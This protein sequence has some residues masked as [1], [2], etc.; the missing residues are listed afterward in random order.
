MS[1]IA[2]VL[3]FERTE[4]DDAQVSEVKVDPGGGANVTAQHFA[5]PG[6][7]SHPLPGDFVATTASPGSGNEHATGY[8][9]P[10]NEPQSGPGEKRIYAR[11]GD[12]AVTAVVWLKSDGEVLVESVEGGSVIRIAPDGGVHLG[13]ASGAAKIPRA[14]RVDAEIDRI[15]QLLTTWTVAPM[16]GGAALQAAANIEVLNVLSTASDKVSGT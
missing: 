7:D 6:D 8:V 12:G 15:W 16:D 4:V 10:A 13:D 5:P 11:N 1:R 3:S 14:D 9:D 2:T